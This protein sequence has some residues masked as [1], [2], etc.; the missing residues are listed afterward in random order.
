MKLLLNKANSSDEL[1]LLSTSAIHNHGNLLLT[2]K[3]M[4]LQN[5]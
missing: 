2:E 5:M 3:L 4:Q 1:A